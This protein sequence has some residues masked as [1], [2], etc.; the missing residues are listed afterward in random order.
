MA[1]YLG[2]EI[3]LEPT[4]E[5]RQEAATGLSWREEYNRGGTDVGVGTANAILSGSE[6]SPE[7]VRTMYA[8][9]ERH[10]VDR[11]A[12]GW[13]RG[14][15]G[16]PSAGKIAWLLWGGDPGRRWATE[17]RDELMSIEASA[18]EQKSFRTAPFKIK[19]L[20]STEMAF[21]GYASVFDTVDS[22]G[23][24]VVR[25]AFQQTLRQASDSGIWPSML[26]QHDQKQPVG[27]WTEMFEDDKGLYV[28]GQLADTSLGRDVYNL[29]GMNALNG[30]SIGYAVKDDSY[31]RE[32]AVR[33]L[34]NI[35]LWEV[36]VV[37]F[38]ANADARVREVKQSGHDA[39]FVEKVLR[40]AGLSRTNAKAIVARGLA[41]L[42]D[43][44]TDDLI[45]SV[46]AERLV[47]MFRS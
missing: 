37:T 3:D 1:R 42:R 2:T 11:Q 29:L 9:F 13:E 12:E 15:E 35:D 28:R 32:R 7:R 17:K 41:G 24:V 40:D 46:D 34:K 19:S 4:G 44:D 43:A 8:Y 23:D 47:Q 30:L 16:F 25:G 36:S 10:A 33:E 26:W 39:R 18:V 5:M 22:Y 38:P 20:D 14:E 21:E 6:L 45:S 31:D 27:V